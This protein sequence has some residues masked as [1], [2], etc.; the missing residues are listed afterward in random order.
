MR[1]LDLW[2]STLNLPG[3]ANAIDRFFDDWSLSP[4]TD[5]KVAVVPRCDINENDK[6]YL[7]KMEVPGLSKDQIKIDLHDNYLT[8]SGERREEKTEKSKDER[9][10]RSEIQ[11]G[12]FLRSFTFPVGVDGEKT[13]ARYE[14]GVLNLTIPKKAVAGA[15]QIPIKS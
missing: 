5:T 2:R 3:G 9:T 13:E 15:R 7:L 8:V 6:A 10:H 4:L 12:S 14:N 1:P 11:Y